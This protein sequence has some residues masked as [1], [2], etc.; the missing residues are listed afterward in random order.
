MVK[1]IY[2]KTH[3]ALVR[4]LVKARKLAGLKQEKVAKK[5]GKTQSYISKIESGQCR[6]D[7]VQIKE[8]AAIYKKNPKDFIE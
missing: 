8:L 5:L 3:K 2:T 4:Q 6:I 1:T 7:I